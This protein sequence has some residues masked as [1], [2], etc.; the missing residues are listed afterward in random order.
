MTDVIVTSLSAATLCTVFVTIFKASVPTAKTWAIMIIALLSGQV[1]SFLVN[2]AGD[3][4]LTLT[5]Q[6]T[7]RII[8]TGVL[9]TAAAAGIR[10]SDQKADEARQP[11]PT[12]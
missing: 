2:Y 8:I 3:E 12:T 5:K 9:A 4:N 1:A 11:P 10:T 7:A 6:L